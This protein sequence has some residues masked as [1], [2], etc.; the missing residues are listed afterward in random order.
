MPP[1]TAAAPTAII[2]TFTSHPTL[3]SANANRAGPHP[4]NRVWRQ[5]SREASP[6]LLW[7]RRF[8]DEPLADLLE[9]FELE[10]EEPTETGPGDDDRQRDL[11][12]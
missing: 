8:L 11:T 9:S 7:G 10:R 4:P 3:I 1:A 2:S 12:I 6:R 5:R